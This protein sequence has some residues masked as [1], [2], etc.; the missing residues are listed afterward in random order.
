MTEWFKATASKT[1]Q[2]TA[3]SIR[4][5]CG[6]NKLLLALLVS[7]TVLRTAPILWGLSLSDFQGAFH[8]DEAK[9]DGVTKGFPQVYLTTDQ[10]RGYGT[11]I[12]Y[13]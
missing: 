8:P 13:P 1:Y 9:V 5:W 6:S 12:Q 2:R 11:S 10:F 3:D 7:G 4:H